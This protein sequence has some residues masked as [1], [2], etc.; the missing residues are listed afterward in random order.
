MKSKAKHGEMIL[1][2]VFVISLPMFGQVRLPR[3]IS[4]GM[5]LQRDARVKLWG[6]AADHEKISV[7]FNDSVYHTSANDKGEWTVVLSGLRPGGPFTMTVNASNSITVED[8]M[9]GDVWIC[10]GQSNMELP[11]K[12]VS[13]VYETE[14]AKSENPYIRH[15]AVPQK[16]NFNTPE[17]D[18]D[19]GKWQTANPKNVL[20]FSAVAYFFGAE[21]YEKYR[22]PVGLINASLGGSPAESWLSEDAIRE[23][24]IHYQ[25]AQTFK[26][27]TV[28]KQIE[29]QDKVRIEAWYG[30]LRQR[31]KG[32]RNPLKPWYDPDLDAADWTSMN[33]PGYWASTELGGNI[34]GC[35]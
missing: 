13:P 6:W 26:D 11:M 15:F 10:S 30:Q 20:S 12:R 7:V 29:N 9:I 17:D 22:V 3:L 33:V 21:L 28:I 19:S 14:I 2:L 18:L 4:D 35:V 23:F 24:P 16:Y 25:E 8:I 34:L 27:P 32:Y 5:V 31:D 1:I